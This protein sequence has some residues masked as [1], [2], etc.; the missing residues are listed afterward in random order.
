MT[1]RREQGAIRTLEL[2]QGSERSRASLRLWEQGK[3]A[4]EYVNDGM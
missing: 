4:N 1:Q 3:G 2:H